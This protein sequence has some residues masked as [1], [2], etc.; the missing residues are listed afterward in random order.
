METD[1]G[2]IRDRKLSILTVNTDSGI[3]SVNNEDDDHTTAHD[4]LRADD[5]EQESLEMKVRFRVSL[6]EHGRDVMDLRKF[7]ETTAKSR[8][9]CSLPDILDF[10][11]EEIFQPDE[12]C[13]SQTFSPSIAN[14]SFTSISTICGAVENRKPDSGSGSPEYETKEGNKLCGKEHKEKPCFIC[15]KDNEI[16]CR[17][18][19]MIHNYHCK[20]KVKHIP[21]I[22]PEMR[23]NLCQNASKDL[24]VMKKRFEKIRIENEA[25]VKN[26]EE[27]R[28][29]F[30]RSLIEFKNKII[31]V[32]D[33]M[34]KEALSRMD[35]IYGQEKRKL[36]RTMFAIEK[37]ISDIDSYIAIIED[38]MK[39]SE[40]SVVYELQAATDQVRRDETVIRDLHKTTNSVQFEFEPTPEFLEMLSDHDKLWRLERKESSVCNYP[41]PCTCDRS[42]MDKV[43]VKEREASVRLFGLSFDRER[44]CITGCEFLPNG[45]LL[46]CDNSNKKVK[47]F[48]KKFKCVSAQSLQSLPWDVT[49]LDD[50]QAVLTIPDKKELQFFEVH[51][52]ISLKHSLTLQQNCWG[53]SHNNGLLFVTCWSRDKTEV[54]VMD[55]HGTLKHIIT[56]VQGLPFHTPWFIAGFEDTMFVSDWGTYIV[57]NVTSSG[58]PLSK[59]RSSSL[60]GPLGLTRDPDGNIYVCGRDSNNIHQI[61]KDGTDSRIFLTERDG[62]SQPLNVCHRK[63]DDRLIVTSWMSDKVSVFRLH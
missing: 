30:M 45:K 12:T 31:D 14:S 42:Y 22:P 11:V 29:T 15:L 53:V 18:C 35:A 44:C 55:I 59:Y 61:S 47:L 1:Q 39:A 24:A 17:N 51:H 19:V 34:E 25:I 3:S 48:D 63:K 41:N 4:S 27:S 28:K 7:M 13:S 50:A 16:Y 32:I 46:V 60:V 26:L 49:V 8:R 23:T 36:E 6:D 52:K 21:E 5:N 62:I 58:V 43:A 54:V 33:S 40:N 57:Q 56:L 9:S 10:E 2:E 38:C 20:E 37:E